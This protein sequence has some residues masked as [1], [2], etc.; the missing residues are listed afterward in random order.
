MKRFITFVFSFVFV[1]ALFAQDGFNFKGLVTDGSGNPL[2]NQQVDITVQI[3]HSNGSVYYIETHNGTSTD[4]YGIFSI[5]MGEGTRTAGVASFDDIDW[6][7]QGINYNI[8]VNAGS[9]SQMLVSH[10]PFKYVPYAKM[11]NKVNGVQDKI[12]IGASDPRML[13]I[14]GPATNRELA[15]FNVTDISG[16]YDVLELD[17]PNGTQAGDGDFIE[18]KNGGSIVFKIDAIGNIQAD[19]DLNIEGE[20]HSPTAGGADLKPYIYGRVSSTGTI[21]SAS[22]TDGFTVTKTN[23][24]NYKITF[25]TGFS[26]S[27]DYLVVATSLSSTV[28]V[29]VSY[30][31]GY[32]YVF[33]RDISSNNYTDTSFSFVVYKK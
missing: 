19:G 11:A 15:K 16:G 2:S 27:N 28:N 30:A 31:S 3:F 12:N 7:E 23:T 21:V 22:S 18:M 8:F 9:G 26:T 5:I 14:E 17:V 6:S 10:E 24:G 1:G 20:I 32:F 25:D 13:Y 33:T 29:G 4:Q